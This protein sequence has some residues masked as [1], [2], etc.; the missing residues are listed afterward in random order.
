MTFAC[1]KKMLLFATGMFLC[2]SLLCGCA[3][4]M[5]T[6][7]GGSD[8]ASAQM[9]PLSA[10][11]AEKVLATAMA[12]EFAGSPVSRVEFP[13]K[14]Y[15]VTMRS[16]LDSHTV[17]AYMIPARGRNS[18]GEVV[19]GYAFE[20]SHSGTMFAGGS[21]ARRLFERI[22]HESTLAARPLPLVSFGP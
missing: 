5:S 2:L 14:G 22:V 19:S 1:P 15:Q 12:G 18:A 20:V 4:T 6:V 10:E 11:A 17:V 16:A 21:R 13:N 8:K 7:R 3:G 9:F